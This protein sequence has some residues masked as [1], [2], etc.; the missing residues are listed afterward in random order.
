MA[1]AAIIQA[2]GEIQDEKV[3]RQVRLRWSAAVYI[4]ANSSTQGNF[5][6]IKK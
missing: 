5:A 2:V 3:L 6:N 4:Q 1:E